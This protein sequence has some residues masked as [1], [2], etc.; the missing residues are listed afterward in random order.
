MAVMAM[1]TAI[2]NNNY[3]EDYGDPEPPTCTC[4]VSAGL[5]KRLRWLEDDFVL[6]QLAIS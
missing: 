4:M 2:I 6:A 1:V 3:Y 5:G